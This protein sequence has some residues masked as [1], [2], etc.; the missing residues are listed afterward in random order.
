MTARVAIVTAG[1]LATCPR[2]LKA[3]DAL[4][5]AGYRVRVVSGR[6]VAWATAADEDVR[7]ERAGQWE[8]TVVDGD[9]RSAPGSYFWSG[10]RYHASRAVA[11]GLGRAAIPLALAARAYARAHTELLRAALQ[12]PADLYYGGTSGALAAVAAAARRARVPYALDLEDFHSGESDDPAAAPLVHALARGI[13]RAILPRAAFLTA[14][15]AAIGRAYAERY[16]VRPVLV[17]NAFSLPD[18]APELGPA[19]GSGLKLYWFGQTIGPGRGLEDAVRAVGLAGI[20]AE[21]HLRGL[22]VPGYLDSLGRLGGDAAP[23][24]AII[25][26]APASPDRMVELCRGY[27]V[28][29]ALEQGHIANRAWCLTNKAF[30]YIL[31]ALAVAFTDTPGQRRLALDLAEGAILYR[32]ADVAALAAGLRRWEADRGLLLRAKAAAWEAA[33][34]RWHWE[35]REERGAL[36]DAVAAALG[37]RV[38]CA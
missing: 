31:A 26:H 37:S 7:S 33:R 3:A 4:A 5:G 27:D 32:P 28:G 9:R 38:P 22:A 8:W 16:G 34:R 30:T 11:R 6:S 14:S 10:A 29:L 36:L 25:H 12:Q 2:M 18:R 13:E 15:S 23:R 20:S 17:H 1:H 35:H 21:L 19:A 24:L